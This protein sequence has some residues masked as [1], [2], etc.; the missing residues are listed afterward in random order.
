M[1][2]LDQLGFYQQKCEQVKERKTWEK[3]G[4]ME[5]IKVFFMDAFILAL[6]ALYKDHR[7]VFGF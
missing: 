2:V 7:K 5:E 3:E 1:Y 4:E 6:H